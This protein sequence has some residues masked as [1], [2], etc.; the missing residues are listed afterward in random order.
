MI[1]IEPTHIEELENLVKSNGQVNSYRN[2]LRSDYNTSTVP[3]NS[4]ILQETT[5]TRV[6]KGGKASGV[7]PS[8]NKPLVSAASK[9]KSQISNRM[10]N[11]NG[12][13]LLSPC[14]HRQDNKLPQQLNEHSNPIKNKRTIS[15]NKL[16]VDS[17]IPPKK[18]PS[19]VEKDV[20]VSHKRRGSVQS[21]N[22]SRRVKEGVMLPRVVQKPSFDLSAGKLNLALSKRNGNRG[23]YSPRQRSEQLARYGAKIIKDPKAENVK[24]LVERLKQSLSPLAE[25]PEVFELTSSRIFE[26]ANPEERRHRRRRSDRIKAKLISNHDSLVKENLVNVV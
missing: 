5:N 1:E 11:F 12:N 26:N 23:F 20:T 8:A 7:M 3:I 13:R 16:R 2:T 19:K 25:K 21:N 17:N 18:E 10:L 24:L 15:H 14:S 4:R 22:K 6:D 9:M